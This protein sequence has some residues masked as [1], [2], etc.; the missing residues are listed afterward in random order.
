MSKSEAG[1]LGER[2]A[3][4]KR[5]EIIV[6]LSAYVDKAYLNYLS[7]WKTSHLERLL[8]AYKEK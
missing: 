1:K 4:K 6:R 2:I 3:H 8:R 7:K 5:Y